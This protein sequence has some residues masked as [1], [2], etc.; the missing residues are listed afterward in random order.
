VS[1]WAANELGLVLA[2][3]LL[4][5]ATLALL[6]RVGSWQI[7]RAASLTLD[8]GLRIGSQAPHLVGSTSTYQI[9]I[10]WDGGRLA[11]VAFGNHGCRPCDELLAVAPNHPATRHM[12]LIYMTD[13]LVEADAPGSWEI[14]Q[15]DDEAYARELW[16]APVSPYFYVVDPYGRVAEK[17][18]ANAADHL[19][20]LLALLPPAVSPSIAFAPSEIKERGALDAR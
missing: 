20:R 8:E 1:A 15:Y 3:V 19:D 5:L 6:W 11:F 10:G 18:I 2:A 14:Y 13:K 17:G 4:G 9:D 16:R 7:H 12:R